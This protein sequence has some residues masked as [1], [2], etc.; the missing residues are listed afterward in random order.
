M[1]PYKSKF[2]LV[3]RPMD[4]GA[5]TAKDKNKKSFNF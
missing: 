5:A 2:T 1:K 4:L 3:S